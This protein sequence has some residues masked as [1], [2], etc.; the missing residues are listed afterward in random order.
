MTTSDTAQRWSPLPR[1]N[2]TRGFRF[3]TAAWF[4]ANAVIVVVLGA[5]GMH[6]LLS[7]IHHRDEAIWN[8]A[9]VA[10]D[11]MRL[12]ES[13]ERKSAASRGYYLTGDPALITVG[14][15][16]RHEFLETLGEL[17]PR[18][19]EPE[20]RTLIERIEASERSHEAALLDAVAHRA[21]S[22]SS[23]DVVGQFEARILPIHD[24]T[25]ASLGE[26]NGYTAEL[27]TNALLVAQEEERRAVWLFGVIASACLLI[28]LLA[29]PNVVRWLW[30][31][32][33]REHE[34]RVSEESAHAVER[35]E[36]A[37]IEAF[38]MGAPALVTITH[39]PDHVV[40]FMNRQAQLAW[41]ELKTGMP[42]HYAPAGDARI[43]EIRDRV[44]RTG[45]QVT[46]RDVR[47]DSDS[48]HDGASPRY[49]TFVH[50]PI[51]GPDEQVEGIMEF[52]FE[53]TE[54]VDARTVAESSTEKLERLAE[55]RE[56]FVSMVSHDLRN[57][58]S[59]IIFGAHMLSDRTLP[60]DATR[61]VGRIGR[62]A[63]RMDRIL[64]ELVDFARTRQGDGLRI[65][66]SEADLVQIVRSV[67]QEAQLSHPDREFIIEDRE[68]LR[69]SW[70]AGRLEQ[71]VSNLL[72]NAI[73]HGDHGA[74]YLRVARRRG[75]AV[76]EV[77]NN[78]NPIAP[79]AIPVLFDPFQRASP[80]KEGLGLGLYIVREIVHAHG[81]EIRVQS[82][83]PR[84]LTTFSLELPM[85]GFDDASRR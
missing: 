74:I 57:P 49:F 14:A 26:L 38:L 80:H 20:A 34:A 29:G 64:S 84:G 31:S 25:S 60:A 41:P 59:A 40:E 36:R 62:S 46:S 9:H 27:H 24:A 28:G 13:F 79:E 82:P 15:D 48:S 44:F 23:D 53:V 42:L 22:G 39:G 30:R 61:V 67:V 69:G 77:A 52:G 5:T 35:G 12:K 11:A 45:R 51:R 85:S 32:Y 73:R 65:E 81:G 68:S 56:R 78:G 70:D 33:E 50:L 37:R 21:Q 55:E 16:A 43:L 83:D 8:G 54:L 10:I 17:K 2:Y 1:R 76:L 6:A 18:L 47:L 75:R 4:A 72:S 63:H 58:L 7:T 3:K 71:V 19:V 66:R